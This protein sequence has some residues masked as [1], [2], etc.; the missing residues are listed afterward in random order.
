MS[1]FSEVVYKKKPFNIKKELT[2]LKDHYIIVSKSRNFF[3]YLPLETDFREM[4]KETVYYY[5][6]WNLSSPDNNTV[7]DGVAN[8]YELALEKE[9]VIFYMDAHRLPIVKQ[10]FLEHFHKNVEFYKLRDD[11]Y[12]MKII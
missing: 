8:F 5:I 12:K 6:G 7:L 4:F 10:Y 11:Y 1:L 2:T 3:T 9:N